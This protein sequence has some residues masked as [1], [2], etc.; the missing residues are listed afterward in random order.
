MSVRFSANEE[1]SLTPLTK[2]CCSDMNIVVRKGSILRRTGISDVDSRRRKSG[3]AIMSDADSPRESGLTPCPNNSILQIK[4]GDSSARLTTSDRQMGSSLIPSDEAGSISSASFQR[5][6]DLPQSTAELDRQT[7]EFTINSSPSVMSYGTSST[8]L[9]T[10]TMSDGEYS[11]RLETIKNKRK[12]FQR[13]GDNSVHDAVMNVSRHRSVRSSHNI[14]ELQLKRSRKKANSQSGTVTSHYR[15]IL[16]RRAESVRTKNK[17]PDA[18]K[19]REMVDAGLDPHAAPECALVEETHERQRQ[20]SMKSSMSLARLRKLRLELTG[21]SSPASISRVTKGSSNNC[22]SPANNSNTPT[23]G[24]P[25]EPFPLSFELL[26]FDAVSDVSFNCKGRLSKYSSICSSQCSRVATR[27]T[28]TESGNFSLP[29][30]NTPDEA[31]HGTD[32]FSER[33]RRCHSIAVGLQDAEYRH[34]IPDQPGGEDI[35]FGRSQRDQLFAPHN[36]NQ[37]SSVLKEFSDDFRVLAMFSVKT[38][39]AEQT[40]SST[41]NSSSLLT[42]LSEHPLEE[43][44][45]AADDLANELEDAEKQADVEVAERQTLADELPVDISFSSGLSVRPVGQP[46]LHLPPPEPVKKLQR[47]SSERTVESKFASLPINSSI[48]DSLVKK[49]NLSFLEDGCESPRRILSSIIEESITFHTCAHSS[50]LAVARVR[51]SSM[52][53]SIQHYLGSPR[54]SIDIVNEEGPIPALPPTTP[55]YRKHHAHSLLINAV[56]TMMIKQGPS[57]Y[58]AGQ[59]AL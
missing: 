13:L 19:V 57:F 20:K 52:V 30:S 50:S 12:V 54:T 38:I 29:S 35:M 1:Q 7:L 36:K 23:D 47:A 32:R 44:L 37:G 24:F 55:T 28:P 45:T 10:E 33:R 46:I 9:S 8:A 5:P 6:S 34:F 56:R 15:E 18:A 4:T 59:L 41:R 2:T 16:Q 17:L 58:I 40:K 49:C 3:G 39:P 26:D 51:A 11:R 31:K 21:Q 14:T 43:I 22:S 48:N 27:F 25:V 53:K 42:P